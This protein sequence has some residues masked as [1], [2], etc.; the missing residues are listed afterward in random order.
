METIKEAADDW[1][2]EFGDGAHNA[3]E[4]RAILARHIQGKEGV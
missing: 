3:V 1:A 2:H 4:L